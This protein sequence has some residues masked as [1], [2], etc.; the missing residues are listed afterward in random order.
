MTFKTISKS[1]MNKL[2]YYL[3]FLVLVSMVIPASAQNPSMSDEELKIQ[4]QVQACYSQVDAKELT[5]AEKTVAKRDCE[6]TINNKYNEENNDHHDLAEK[7]YRY[8]VMQKCEDWYPAYRLLDE[9][10]WRIQ[11]NSEQASDCIMIYNDNVWKYSGE[12]KS[13]VL[14]ER[15]LELKEESTIPK[16]VASSIELLSQSDIVAQDTRF[17]K[18]TDLEAKVAELQEE[19]RKKNEVI[20]EQI[21]VIMNLANMLRNIVLESFLTNFIHI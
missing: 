7:K 11:K 18:M 3:V 1:E 21:K 14:I 10:R 12:D 19:L 4:E 13:D 5:T 17:S 6:T 8:E 20:S 9:Q 2:G 16:P 15:L